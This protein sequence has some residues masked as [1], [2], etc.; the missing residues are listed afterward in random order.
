MGRPASRV[1]RVVVTGPLAPFAPVLRARLREAG[2]TPLST[3]VVMRLM[4][5]LSRWLDVNGVGVTGLGREQVERYI[6]ARRAEGRTSGLSPLSLDPILAMLT[7]AGALMPEPPAGPASDDE[8]L[9]AAFERHL[10]CERALAGATAAAHLA[11][12]RRFGAGRVGRGHAVTGA[13]LAEAGT[14][15]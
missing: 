4:A 6:A 12:A 5:H 14:V 15:S 11:G 3:V 10:L 7:D 1:A 8:R 9:L 2:Y 13:V